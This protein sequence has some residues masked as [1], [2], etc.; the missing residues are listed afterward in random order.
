MTSSFLPN[1]EE[2]TVICYLSDEV[3][4]ISNNGSQFLWLRNRQPLLAA[5]SKRYWHSNFVCGGEFQMDFHQNLNI[6][7]RAFFKKAGNLNLHY[8][9]EQSTVYFAPKSSTNSNFPPFWKKPSRKYLDLDENPFTDGSSQ[10]LLLIHNMSM[11]T[12]AVGAALFMAS[13]QKV[14]LHSDSIISNYP[15]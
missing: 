15:F 8:F 4:G 7:S 10:C 3:T 13:G 1:W 2:V 9:L 11:H 5:F 6:F 14:L 12:P